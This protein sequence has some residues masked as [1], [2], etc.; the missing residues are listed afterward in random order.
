MENYLE[1][2]ETLNDLIAINNDRISDYEKAIHDISSEDA[3]L[4]RFF[5]NRIDESHKFKM[6]LGTEVEV[7]GK[8]IDNTGTVNGRLH[9]A[10]LQVKEAF[11]GHSTRSILDECEFTEDGI[12]KAYRDALNNNNLPAYIREILFNQQATLNAAHDEVKYLRDH[13]H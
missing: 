1:T 4:K 13:V 3:D 12:S 8:D 7:L 11:S 6:Q 5:M 9:R 10:W 2:I